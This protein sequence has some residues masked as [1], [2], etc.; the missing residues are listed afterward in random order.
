MAWLSALARGEY[1]EPVGRNGRPVSRKRD[2]VSLRRP[3]AT[4]REV[5][6]SLGTLTAEMRSNAEERARI[7]AARDEWVAGVSHDLRT[8]LTSIR[9]YADILASDYEFEAQ[10]VRRQAAVIATQAGHM[11]ELLDDLNL[12]FRLRAD[13][14][15]LSRTSVDLI[16]LAREAAVSLANDPRAAHTHVVFDEPPGSGPIMVS[17]DPM[18]LRRAMANLLVNAAVHNPGGTT[19]RV[20]VAHESPWALVRVADDGV[21]M[22]DA[23]RGRLF[24]RYFR[25]TSTRVDAEGT[26]LGMAITRQIVVAHGGVIDVASTS[27][28]GTVVQ[29]ALPVGSS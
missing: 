21:G 22:D 17:V 25:G 23:T 19:V 8:P 2:G 20:T 11:D 9:G 18:L 5:F 1:A 29:I 16:E 27:G 6:S 10:E 14:L 4:Y 13:A 7:E 12:S 15:A 3:Y 28:H 26:G 24:D